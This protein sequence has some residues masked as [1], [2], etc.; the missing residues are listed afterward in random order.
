MV[1]TTWWMVRNIETIASIE[2]ECEETARNNFFDDWDLSAEIT[3]KNIRE[4][5]QREICREEWN[6]RER[7]SARFDDE[8]IT[9]KTASPSQ[10]IRD[11]SAI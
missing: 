11:P 2:N 7:L 10:H 1:E 5:C 3:T 4:I 9:S 8:I 6:S